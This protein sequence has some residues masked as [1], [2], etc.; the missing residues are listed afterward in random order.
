MLQRI[1]KFWQI[2]DVQ[3]RCAKLNSLFKKYL[4]L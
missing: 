3:K 2:S 4:E 1:T